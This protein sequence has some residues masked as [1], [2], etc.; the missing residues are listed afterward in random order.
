MP[1]WIRQ[2]LPLVLLGVIVLALLFG[3]RVAV[4]L[5]DFWWFREIGA[6]EVFT[7]VL[8]TRILLTVVGGL[9]A[10]A[11]IVATLQVARRLRPT[12]VPASPQQAAIEQY[13]NQA[14]PYLKWLVGGV[15]ALFG[16]SSGLALGSAWATFLLWRNGGEFGQVDP[17]FGRDVG[18]FVFE[19]P[20]WQ[21]VQSW[22]F[23]T[24]VL[25]TML[26]AG[27]HLLLGG[28][29]PDA[30]R[31][32]VLPA[33]KVHLSVLLIGLLAL[34]GW[35]YWLDRYELDF[36]ERGTVTGASYTDVNAELPALYLLLAA[37]VVAIVLVLWG[38]RQNSFTL[39]GVAIA[40]LVVSSIVLQGA[41]PAAIQRLRVDP[42]ELNRERQYIA[43]N[44]EMTRTAYELTDLD[45]NNFDIA[46]NLDAQQIESNETTFANIR[47]WDPDLL[48]DNYQEL[49]SLRPFYEFHDVDIDRYLIDGQP[50]QVMLSARELDPEAD[51]VAGQWQ[52]QRLTYTH[53]Y[54]VVASQVNTATN[55][56]QPVFLASDIPP[57]T[58]EAIA[59]DAG[60]VPEEPGMYYAS[61]GFLDYAIVDTEQP[62]LDY[63]QPD[64][65]RQETVRYAGEGGV[66]L[67][68]LGSRLAWAMRYSDPNFVLSNL[69]RD[70]SRVVLHREVPDRI[71]EVAPYLKLDRDPYAVVMED[72][73][74]WVQDAYTT[75]TR[76][77]YS[78]YRNFAHAD[79]SDT[80]NYVRNSVKAVVDSYDGTVTLYV[81]EPDD[82]IVQAWRKAFPSLY[83][84]FEDAPD[85]LVSHFRYPEDLFTLQA[86]LYATYHIPEAEQFYNRADS[87]AIPRDAAQ[88]ENDNDSGNPPLDPYYL[89]T[90]L[91]GEPEA[92]FVMIQ[93]YVPANRQNMV[94]W[95]A[96]RSDPEHYGELFAVR[97]PTNDN[98]LGPVQAHGRI[99][100]ESEIAERITLVDQQ[101]SSLIRGNLLVLPVEES[102]LFVE[103][104]F[105][106]NQQSRIPELWQ[107]VLVMGDRVVMRPTLE[108]ALQALVTGGPPVSPDPTA[109]LGTTGDG[110]DDAGADPDTP[111]SP[112]P[113][114]APSEAATGSE[115]PGTPATPPPG[116]DVD[117]DADPG[118]LVQEALDLFTRADAALAE[119][120]LGTYQDL[121]DQ[122]R[123]RLERLDELGVLDGAVPAPSGEPSPA[124]TAGG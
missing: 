98:V 100:Q 115:A 113:T 24:L 59:P 29:R 27:A 80:V 106:V 35:G 42:Q 118:Q 12:V 120:D 105:L 86:D 11:V 82:P 21:L 70:D 52:N 14:E 40:L 2:R 3:N 8:F 104:L 33:V 31:D 19:L 47:L 84:D 92:E 85:E 75:T 122:A 116:G 108:G 83:A 110:G 67:G 65:Q 30:E 95:L 62:E 76:Y 81:S 57:Q 23:T 114:D 22:A 71:R 38:L 16:L 96:A 94:A 90:R 109:G 99:E 13:R 79:G 20:W 15:A 91:P 32:K 61:D 18:F 103:P 123:Q 124:P 97:F 50:R 87:W 58:N 66:P 112:E 51:I 41:Y 63:E 78:E 1:S 37:T 102:I 26:T 34:R 10:G 28:I 117:P 107:V 49:Q 88:I 64:T 77:P 36:S 60:L 111:A 46:N 121:T 93:P 72:R 44:L 74:V 101:G 5:T 39:P 6:R 25:V 119:G 43:A 89:I 54:G 45:L 73:V 56:G 53:G 7:G 9:V 68:G 17:Q 55:A 48:Q 4:F 69:L